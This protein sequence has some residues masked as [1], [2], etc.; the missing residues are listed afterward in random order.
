MLN[1][2]LRK[3][4]SIFGNRITKA[5]IPL[6]S[7]P[8]IRETMIDVANDRNKIKTIVEKLDATFRKNKLRSMFVKDD[9]F[10]PVFGADMDHPLSDLE[11]LL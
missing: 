7:G 2:P 8:K 1:P 5:K 4:T 9:N 10:F 3:R 6:F 11:R